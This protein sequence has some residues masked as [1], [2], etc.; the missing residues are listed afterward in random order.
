MM[1]TNPVL[2]TATLTFPKTIIIC[3]NLHWLALL[4][5]IFAS[6]ATYAK[7]DSVSIPE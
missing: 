4:M 7:R 1:V 5:V 2:I 3:T 6:I